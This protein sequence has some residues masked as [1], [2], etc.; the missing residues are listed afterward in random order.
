MKINLITVLGPTAVGKTS[1]ASR[2]AEEFSGE[3]I[4]ADSR[5]VYRGM[6]SGTGKDLEEFRNRKIN[7]HLIDIVEPTEEYNLFRFKK[8]FYSAFEK[9]ISKN[10]LPIMV[11]G[12]G[13]YLSSIL[14]KYDLKKIEIDQAEFE[15]LNNLTIEDLQNILL[16]LRPAQHNTTDLIDK[17]RLI[18][19]ILIEKA[20]QI[21]FPVE[22]FRGINSFNIGITASRDEIKKRITS[23]LKHRLKNGMIEEVESL[24]KIIDHEKL[25]FFGLEYKFISL[26]LLG[27]ISY[28]DM[29][30]K[31]NIAIHKF[32]K[33]QMTWFRK[34]EKE[35]VNINWF[36]PEESDKIISFLKSEL[37]NNF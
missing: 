31:L 28:D 26:Y 2:I 27:E 34:M 32:S 25:Q 12:T 11:G 15:A 17:S 21:G 3:I 14:Q 10:K 36:E 16:E 33:R 35:G 19:A 7:Y 37:K 30:Q 20:S 4:S 18:K 13:L 24:L 5:Q 6:D 23:R 22:S 1:V 9:I 8:D 29:F